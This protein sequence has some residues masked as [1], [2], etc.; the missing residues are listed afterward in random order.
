MPN[1]TAA[2]ANPGAAANP[3]AMKDAAI[4]LVRRYRTTI[5]GLNQSLILSRAETVAARADMDLRRSY[6]YPSANSGNAN[7]MANTGVTGVANPD[8]AANPDPI[9]LAKQLFN[10]IRDLERRVRDSQAETEAV[11]AQIDSLQ[12]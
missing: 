9:A 6:F 11:R 12:T 1:N 8:A 10:E 3:G 4:I 7:L 5:R 2:T